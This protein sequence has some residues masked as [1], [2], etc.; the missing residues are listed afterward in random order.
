MHAACAK[1]IRLIIRAL[2]LVAVVLRSGSSRP[3]MDEVVV[4]GG[5]CTAAIVKTSG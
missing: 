3:P 1:V 2:R 4:H 5:C